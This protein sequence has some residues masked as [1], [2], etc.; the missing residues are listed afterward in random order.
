MFE[1]NIRGGVSTISHRY[2]RSNNPGTTKFNPQ[3]DP[4]HILYVDA[5]NLYGWVMS[6]KLPTGN[7]QFL[8]DDEREKFDVFSISDD[9]EMGYVI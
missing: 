9:S 3:E 1:S 4:A 8:N 5:N 2:A 6:Q 7:F